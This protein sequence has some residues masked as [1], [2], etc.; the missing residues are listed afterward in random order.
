MELLAWTYYTKQTASI[1]YFILLVFLIDGSDIKFFTLKSFFLFTMPFFYFGF[2]PFYFDPDKATTN[3]SQYVWCACFCKPDDTPCAVWIWYFDLSW[4]Y[5]C[6]P[7]A[8]NIYISDD[9]FSDFGFFYHFHL[10]QYICNSMSFDVVVYTLIAL[11]IVDCI[12]YLHTFTEAYS[13]E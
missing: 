10:C 13:I 5:S 7:S 9:A 3:T 8:D 11:A 6:A 2:I 1:L 12:L 4:L